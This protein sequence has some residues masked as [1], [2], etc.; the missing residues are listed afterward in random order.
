MAP[1][2]VSRTTDLVYLETLVDL[3]RTGLPSEKIADELQRR[4]PDR[5][6]HLGPRAIRKRL[7]QA[8]GP[9]ATRAAI[10]GEADSDIWWNLAE[11]DLDE[12]RSVM[13][14][15]RAAMEHVAAPVRMRR[16]VAQWIHR[17]RTLSPGMPPLVAWSL[18]LEYDRPP[19]VA[20]RSSLDRYVVLELWRD[21]TE[22][23]KWIEAGWLEAPLTAWRVGPERVNE[24]E[25]TGA[26][27]ALEAVFL[28]LSQVDVTGRNPDRL[29]DLQV[30]MEL[31]REAAAAA[32]AEAEQEAAPLVRPSDDRGGAQ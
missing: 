14:A 8:L 26:R 16:S 6:H 4:F 27:R 12:A 29:P 30:A 13:P 3:G 23:E 25:R 28:E 5:E 7:N 21:R 18:A 15:W 11:A 32:L 1:R 9:A 10:D 17:L 24:S 19:P 31:F 20:N 22:L 2:S